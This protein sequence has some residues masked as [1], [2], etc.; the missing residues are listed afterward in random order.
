LKR[1]HG[2]DRVGAA[3]RLCAGLRQPE[4]LHFAFLDQLLDRS[5][6]VLDRHVWIDAMLIEEVDPIGLQ[7][8]QRR[9]GDLA[10]VRRSAV[11]P[12]ALSV[13]ELEAEFGG[14]HNLIANR[15]KGI[16]DQLFVRVRT[17]RLG[18]V[19]ER[20]PTVNSRPDDSDAFLPWAGRAVAK[21]DAHAAEANRR[22]LESAVAQCTFVHRTRLL[23]GPS[24]LTRRVVRQHG[25]ALR[26][27]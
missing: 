23:H 22:H 1:R 18:C 15:G 4:V 12:G 17:V 2:L 16:P 14:D 27:C 24:P 11:Q 3:D 9:L 5:G 25:T 19:E 13:L 20:D 6:H 21:A 7:S 10:D 26:P 8:L